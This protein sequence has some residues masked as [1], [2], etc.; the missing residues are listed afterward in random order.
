MKQRFSKD[1][2]H[3]CQ[4]FGNRWSANAS[5]NAPQSFGPGASSLVCYTVFILG[6]GMRVSVKHRLISLSLSASISLSLS[7]TRMHA[8]THAHISM[9]EGKTEHR[10]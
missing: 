3:L 2:V 7:H 5:C 9:R 1:V 8:R 4:Y 10:M 6:P